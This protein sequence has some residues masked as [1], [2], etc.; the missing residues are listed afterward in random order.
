MNRTAWMLFL[1]ASALALGCSDDHTHSHEGHARHAPPAV[2]AA[3]FNQLSS[4]VGARI[5][6]FHDPDGRTFGA[7]LITGSDFRAE[8][9]DRYAP[10]R[11]YWR[12]DGDVDFSEKA[13][14]TIH[15][16]WS[17]AVLWEK[18]EKYAFKDPFKNWTEFEVN[19]G[20]TLAEEPTTLAAAPGKSKYLYSV[21][22]PAPAGMWEDPTT[23]NFLEYHVLFD[24]SDDRNPRVTWSLAEDN[25]DTYELARSYATSPDTTMVSDWSLRADAR[26]VLFFGSAVAGRIDRGTGFIYSAIDAPEPA[27][28]VCPRHGVVH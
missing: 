12:L 25:F 6:H 18:V 27:G 11:E 28:E 3:H 22:G 9:G 21:Y 16:V 1:A 14:F 26:E 10:D 24:M 7:V 4:G 2:G 8:R 23:A 17:G 13:K 5:Y 20:F 19:R 15:V